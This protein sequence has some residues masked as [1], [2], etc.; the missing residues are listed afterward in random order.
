MT[1]GLAATAAAWY[2]LIVKHVVRGRIAAFLG[3]S[4]AA[5]AP[6]MVSHAHAHPNFVVLF[7]IPLIIDRALRL[8]AGC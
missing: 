3:A 5:F 2:Q 8:C 4:L 7:M 6:P 1:L